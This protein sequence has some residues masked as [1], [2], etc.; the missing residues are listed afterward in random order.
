M[1][2][3]NSYSVR[4]RAIATL[5]S[6]YPQYTWTLPSEAR[7]GNNTW[8]NLVRLSSEILTYSPDVLL[9][10]TVNDTN[11]DW[12]LASLE[13]YIRRIWTARP[14]AR[15]AVFNFF[16]VASQLVNANVN[17]PANQDAIESME[18]LL[19]H[20]GIQ[21]LDYWGTIQDL[22]NNQGHNLSEYMDDTVHPNATGHNVAYTLLLPYLP[23]GMGAAP[24]PL[25]NRLYDDGTMENTPTIRNGTANSG[26]T[27]VWS[28]VAT[29][30]RQSSAVGA[31]IAFNGVAC[32][33]IGAYR[34]DGGSNPTVQISIDG[35]AFYNFTLYQN[36]GQLAE[37]FDTHDI[38]IKVVSGTIRIDE[39]W[40][41]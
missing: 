35:G 6:D 12:Q 30:G 40:A 33:T 37:G 13:A 26:E 22:V 23:F 15:L 19:A 11:E 36:G 3:S 1:S 31:T 34:A 28:T 32:S 29:I 18:A 25:P 7:S 20:Y 9:L 16:A 8:S 21:L 17:S 39:F 24:S 41:V 4:S 10:E 38:V 14:S 5:L 2:N 27:G